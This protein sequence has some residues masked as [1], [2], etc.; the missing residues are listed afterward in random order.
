MSGQLNDLEVEYYTKALEGTLPGQGLTP[1]QEEILDSVENMT[2][3]YVPI[4]DP[5]G[6]GFVDSQMFQDAEGT[7]ITPGDIQSGTN[8]FKLDL[9]WLMDSAGFGVRM[10]NQGSDE[11]FNMM[12]SRFDKMRHP[13]LVKVRNGNPLDSGNDF[14]LPINLVDTDILT[15]PDY[16]I[17]AIPPISDEEGQTATTALVKIDPSS[18]LTNWKLEF[19][20]NGTLYTIFRDNVTAGDYV[21]TYEPEIDIPVGATLQVKITSEDGDV[22]MLGD[23]VSGIPYLIQNVQQFNNKEIYHLEDDI[24]RYVDSTSSAEAKIINN[25]ETIAAD[26]TAGAFT[27]SVDVNDVDSF[28]VFDFAGNWNGGS[29]K[30]TVSLSNGDTYELTVRRRI[31]FFYK[32]ENGDWQWYFENRRPG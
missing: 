26:G 21:F 19:T 29:R 32:D 9:A 20:I 30:V 31:Y 27:L 4:K 16:T 3:R 5:V 23:S 15:N 22:K 12:L 24:P 14:A 6:N 13:G 1:V 2:D 18:V 8:T 25:V 28:Q 7:L 11:S 17:P 10:K